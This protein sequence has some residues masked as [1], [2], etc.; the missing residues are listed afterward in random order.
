MSRQ[1]SLVSNRPPDS[2]GRQKVDPAVRRR[3]VVADEIDRSLRMPLARYLR[4]SRIMA[5]NYST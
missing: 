5:V 1:L 4:H 3:S 2:T